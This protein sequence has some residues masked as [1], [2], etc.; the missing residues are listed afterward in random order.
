MILVRAESAAPRNSS[1]SEF[2]DANAMRRSTGKRRRSSGTDP[3][4]TSSSYTPSRPSH[5]GLANI[6]LAEN[7]LGSR[8]T[9]A[10]TVLFASTSVLAQKRFR[11]RVGSW[12]TLYRETKQLKIWLTVI[13]VGIEKSAAER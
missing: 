11:P 12:Q 4:R 13:R 1:F 2:A 6:D 5:R 7:F 9:S 8:L 10:A 3:T